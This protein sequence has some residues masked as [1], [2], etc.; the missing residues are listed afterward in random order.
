MAGGLSAGQVSV[1]VKPD[2][3]KFGGE[4]RT[5]IMGGVSGIGESL[6]S[7]LMKGLG[8][9]GIAT[10]IGGA[11]KTGFSE[12]A[13]AS[14]GTAQ[15]AAG[16]KSTGNAAN[17]TVDGLNNLASSIQGYSGQTDD[18]IVKSEQLLLT[19]TNVK[20]GVGAGNDIF[21][22][23]TKATADM[24]AK[25]GGDASSSAIQLGKALNDP[26]KGITALT[27]VGVSF[28]E[29]QKNQ[30]KSMVAAGDTMG[31]Q[32]I[33]LGELN[34]EFGGAAS[35][36]G[37]SLPGMIDRMKRSWEDLTQTLASTLLP[38]INPI[39]QGVLNLFKMVQPYVQQFAD[40]F[41]GL[42]VSIGDVGPVIAQVTS[43]FS[44]FGLVL[45]ALQPI[46]PDLIKSV[47]GLA[48][49]I[50]DFLGS[51]FKQ[52]MPLVMQI[53]A[54]LIQLT[55]S[56]IRPL[57][58]VAGQLIQAVIKLAEA[59][60]PVVGSLL[61]PMVSLL[62]ALLPVVMPLASF[63]SSVLVVA[64]KLVAGV[65]VTVINAV[66]NTITWFSKLTA[67]VANSGSGISDWFKKLPSLILNAV[68]N[69]GQWLV[70]AG[71]NIIQGL[72]NG[73]SS[74]IGSVTRTVTGIGS[75]VVNTFKSLLGIHSPS[76]VFH[77]FGTNIADGLANGMVAGKSNVVSVAGTMA[78]DLVDRV[79][80]SLTSLRDAASQAVADAKKTLTDYA[81][82]V[83]DA[84]SGGINF[85]QALSDEDAA[86]QQAKDS[87]ATFGG[88]FIQSLQTQ[89]AQATKFTDDVKKLVAGGLSKDALQ[90]V[91]QAGQD[92]GD[93]I[94]QE[95]LNGGSD[96]IK[97]ANTLIDASKAAAKAAA[98]M[99]AGAYYQAGVD[100]ANQ[101][102]AGYEAAL[103]RG[104]ASSAAAKTVASNTALADRMASASTSVA[105]AAQAT[106][107]PV[108][109]IVYN[110]A[111]NDSIS[112]EQKL[113][114]AVNRAA[115]LART[116]GL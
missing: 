90:Q 79:K 55:V 3:S 68:S 19:F 50:S 74:M 42:G 5:G 114:D 40:K 97:K 66:T 49:Q 110:A 86:K 27:R 53:A 58:P 41:T 70:D 109:Q 25:M 116:G 106:V 2:T 84:L 13:D 61:P 45:K 108:T 73:I 105:K 115:V 100:S 51:A 30:I 65:L 76:V 43:L 22:Q 20:N 91:L 60:L 15:L 56:V 29:Q 101:Q 93:R 81:S 87:G 32:K 64:I 112:S 89:A 102:L 6:S 54:Q 31:A 113:T 94:A 67:S 77:G 16:I 14:A 1:A 63:L 85:A 62:K 83:K 111:K 88:S 7:T 46:L 80:E 17:V 44:P 10:T 103:S 18:S 28:T 82:S 78:A 34:K 33:I 96:T 52:V 104:L 71:K 38:I 37:Q 48:S 23:A 36:Y 12:L 99:A 39:L 98:D 4:L 75:S 11:L 57:L 47:S 59:I 21:N 8:L 9:V 24:A 95:L 69:A 35:A 92:A 107:A 26:V 72:I